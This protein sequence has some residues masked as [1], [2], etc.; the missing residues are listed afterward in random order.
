[1]EDLTIEEAA[2]DLIETAQANLQK[3]NICVHFMNI[4]VLLKCQF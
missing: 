3:M 1:M 2:N 4:F